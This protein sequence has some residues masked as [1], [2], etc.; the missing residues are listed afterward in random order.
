[1]DHFSHEHPLILNEDYIAR[2]GDVCNACNEEMVSCKSFVFSCSRSII[3]GIRS[4]NAGDV[5]EKCIKFLLHKTCA[6]LPRRIENPRNQKE[7]L[8]LHISPRRDRTVLQYWYHIPGDLYHC[9]ICHITIPWIYCNS[10]FRFF[11][12]LK[13][14]MYQ[15][16]CLR[17]RKFEH[18]AHGQHPLALIQ[19]PSSF[20]CDA[21]NVED[22][23][24][25]MS[26]KCI[27]CPFWMHKS[28]ADAPTSF[29]FQFHN[30]HPLVLS[31]SLPQVYKKFEQHCRLC[32][33]T[34]SWET[35]LYYCP[36]CRFF[37][38]FQCAR[39]SRML[40]C[41]HENEIYPDLVHL[42][43]ANESL[44]N[45]FAEQFIKEF[46]TRENNDEFST[47]RIKDWAHGKHDLQLITID[48]LH[49]QKDGDDKLLICDA[50]A[51]PIRNDGD[52]FYACV[53]CQY[54]LHKFCGELP[55]TMDHVLQDSTLS[56]CKYSEPYK[57]FSCHGCDRKGN[58]ISFNGTQNAHYSM[59]S[60]DSVIDVRLH[61]GCLT[62]PKKIKHESHYHP[63]YFKIKD[64]QAC[65][66][67]GMYALLLHS[68]EGCDFRVCA[69]CILKTK[70]V[71]HRWDPHP[72]HLI[73]D[74]EMV[75]NHE[76]G[77][78]CEFCSNELNPN[79]WFYHCND[80]DLSFHL[81]CYEKLCYLNFSHIKFGA[82]NIFINKLHPHSLT[83]VL[84]KKFRHCGKCRRGI[85]G[86]PVLEC[87]PCKTMFCQR[88]W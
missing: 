8:D 1:M 81:K 79:L 86:E 80:C 85:L 52:L 71:K 62:L 6:E 77:F 75:T 58:G 20:K 38:H 53:L 56:A 22:N 48:E 27:D 25:D 13:C 68:C 45:L 55:R 10:S 78:H 2:E 28:C 72:L 46:N 54:F 36:K 32:K 59:L 26:Y 7:F 16:E 74:P 76:H 83:F 82:T 61:I 37:T 5:D 41:S 69:Q 15:V 65:K 42:P 31:F 49:D 50:C 66:A 70:T 23:T 18:L 60:R 73:Y 84:N 30:K 19:R 67:C 64:V 4:T 9:N 63:L 24:K 40:R 35:W 3:M 17:N 88:C 51:K 47:I 33:G 34:M 14:A 29:L 44:M 12:C 57:L 87:A 43:A 11:V 21:C 39:S